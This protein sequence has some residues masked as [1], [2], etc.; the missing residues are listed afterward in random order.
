M[1]AS[2]MG[3]GEA[4]R[5]LSGKN[6]RKEMALP[7][8]AD[9]QGTNRAFI[10]KFDGKGQSTKGRV[11]MLSDIQGSG[12]SRRAQKT[13]NYIA[14]PS[15]GAMGTNKAF[16][17]KG[18]GQGLRGT[19]K[20]SGFGTNAAFLHK[21][22]GKDQSTKA[23][24]QQLYEWTADMEGTYLPADDVYTGANT[25]MIQISGPGFAHSLTD[26]TNLGGIPGTEPANVLP[27]ESHYVIGH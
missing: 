1:L 10:A 25:K 17:N 27:Y 6:G 26:A 5:T 22:D 21:Y 9:K 18:D 11:Q 16:V 19:S 7:S 12:A 23:K 3:S 15:A 2:I 20:L 24:T 13:R 8:F 4:H 14:L